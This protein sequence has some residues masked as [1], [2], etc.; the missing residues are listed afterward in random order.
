[1]SVTASGRGAGLQGIYSE[2]RLA[3]TAQQPFG[4]LVQGVRPVGLEVWIVF[5]YKERQKVRL[6][7]L[8]YLLY[9]V[10]FGR[11]S[12][13]RPRLTLLLPGSRRFV[14]TCGLACERKRELK[15]LI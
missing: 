3:R 2:L 11:I 9:I 10:L 6:L 5:A 15:S 14:Y 13:I 4:T 8:S 1:M 7:F 12:T